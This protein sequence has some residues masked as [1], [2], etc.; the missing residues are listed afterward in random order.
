[1]KILQAAKP[2]IISSAVDKSELMYLDNGGVN[3]DAHVRSDRK[4]YPTVECF[5]MDLQ[6]KLR[7]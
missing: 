1:M 4:L 3:E 7:K 2:A 6:S 5:N